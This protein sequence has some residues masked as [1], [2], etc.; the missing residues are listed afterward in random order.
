MVAGG[1]GALGR[2]VCD[3]LA[4]RGHDVVV[5][6]RRPGGGAHRQVAWDGVGPGDWYEELEGSAVVNL[7][8]ALVDRRPTPAAVALLTASRVEP[9]LALA[10][11]A[12]AVGGLPVLVQVTT[13]A[14]HGDAGD[15]ELDEA[16]PVGAGPPQMVG[17]ATA[18][19]AAA[20]QVLA[21]RTVVLRTSVVLDRDTPALDRLTGVVRWGLG[22][23]IAGGRQWVSWIHVEDWLAV[24]RASLGPAG[25][26][27]AR[28]GPRGG[29]AGDGAA[30][31]PQRRADGAPCGAPC[32]GRGLRRRPHRWCAS[33]RSCCAPTRRSP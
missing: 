23:P 33:A 5:L 28:R 16:S 2:R 15:A 24:L 22:G 12:R 19:E 25:A 13:A 1:S 14:I 31:G 26:G 10:A 3:D 6:S 8:G 17:V 4:G 32:T 21:E 7:A 20:A 11:A 9:T 29:R 27:V 30:P 18:W